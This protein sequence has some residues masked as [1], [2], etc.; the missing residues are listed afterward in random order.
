MPIYT[1]HCPASG[2]EVD[3]QHGMN[4]RLTTWKQV[5]DT[6]EIDP[7]STPGDTPV[8]RLITGGYM[9]I[10]RPG[11]AM[12]TGGCCGLNGCGD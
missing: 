4:Q 9:L 5:C 7:G 8:E 10:K 1:Y 12:H 2:K 11:Q 3:V 6:A